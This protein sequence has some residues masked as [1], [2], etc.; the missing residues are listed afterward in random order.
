MSIIDIILL[1][2]LAISFI[3][4]MQKGFLTS[5]LATFGFVAAW[6]LA[7]MVNMTLSQQFMTSSLVKWL[8][9][10][11]QFDSFLETIEGAAGT[12]CRDLSAESIKM[13]AG[14][15]EAANLPKAIVNAFS[16]HISSFGTLTVSEYLQQ[17]IFQAAF[18]VVSFVIAFGLGYAIIMLIV[19]LI[20][21]MFRMPKLRGVDGLLGGVL[22]AV[23]GYAIICL[24]VAVIPMAFTALDSNVI[25][26]IMA[27]ST[28]GDFFLNNNSVFRD[29]FNVG[30]QLEKIVMELPKIG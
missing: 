1:S 10:N 2:I 6:V 12:Y 25:R 3:S 27:D 17:T 24:V 7:S 18:N 4:G 13:I 28:V 26:S 23:R 30:G 15:L 22:G 5:L 29:L 20:N 16:A 11:V 19:N 8:S 21:N 9:A 14:Q